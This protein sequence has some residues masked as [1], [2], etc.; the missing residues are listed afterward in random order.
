[1]ASNKPKS[2]K[3]LYASAESLKKKYEATVERAK[4]RAEKEKNN[5]NLCSKKQKLAVKSLNKLKSE[6]TRAT[7]RATKLGQQYR[8]KAKSVSDEAKLNCKTKPRIKKFSAKL[9]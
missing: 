1:M 9:S 2:A 6:L 5:P 4:A 7:A 8:E 3:Q